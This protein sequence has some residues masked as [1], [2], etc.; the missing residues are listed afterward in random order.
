MAKAPGDRYQTCL[1]FA[2]ALRGAGELA[3]DPAAACGRP[4]PAE[5]SAGPVGRPGRRRGGRRSRTGRS[6][7]GRNRTAGT[8]SQ[9]PGSPAQARRPARPLSRRGRGTLARPLSRR[10][11]RRGAADPGGETVPHAVH[12]AGSELSGQ[13]RTIQSA[14]LTARA[15]PMHRRASRTGRP[16]SPTARPASPT[17]RQASRTARPASR[18]G[19]P[20]STPTRQ[21][22]R[23]LALPAG[24]G[25][26]G[27]VSS[28][29]PLA[30]LILAAAA[31]GA[32]RSGV[33]RSLSYP[34]DERLLRIADRRL[35]RHDHARFAY[36]CWALS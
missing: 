34:A 16:P 17:T 1:E 2:A 26:R 32:L 7:A 22:C 19:R 30:V 3:A 8:G 31:I 14:V 25:T 28:S 33:F 15:S 24:A 27:L 13:V 9:E 18:T 20:I 5:H 10:G 36:S 23:A 35:D 6:R 12:H 29:V 21:R 11:L 4:G